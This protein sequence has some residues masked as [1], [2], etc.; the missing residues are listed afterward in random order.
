[1]IWRVW[2]KGEADRCDQS[3]GHELQDPVCKVLEVAGQLFSE[4][5]LC[6]RVVF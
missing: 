3:S 2:G 4:C 1:M 5:L 6:I